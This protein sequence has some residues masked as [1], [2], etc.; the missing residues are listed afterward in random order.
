MA[1]TGV[2]SGRNGVHRSCKDWRGDASRLKSIWSKA[3][4]GSSKTGKRF[5]QK[6]D[7]K[8]GRS[9]VREA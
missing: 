8:S 3:Q 5:G 1:W 4:E 2:R 6:L 9:D 7:M